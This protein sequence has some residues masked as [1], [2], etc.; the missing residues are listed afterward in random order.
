MKFKLF[1][2]KAKAKEVLANNQP[3]LVRAGSKEICIVLSSETI[4]AFQN[5]CAHMGERLHGGKINYLNEIVCPLHTYRFNIKTGE[6]AQGRCNS[7]KTYLV[8]ESDEG[9]FID[10]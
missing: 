10:C 9:I 1:E 6:E 7:L 8:I 3:R 2:S 5:E 4:F